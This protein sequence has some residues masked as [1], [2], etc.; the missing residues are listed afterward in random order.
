MAITI[1]AIVHDG[2]DGAFT[3]LPGGVVERYH[4]PLLD[5]C[6]ETTCERRHATHAEL[7]TFA[8]E[9]ADR[10]FEAGWDRAKGER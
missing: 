7:N 1:G 9:D 6:T 8:V 5:V 2:R 10:A 3:R 4:H